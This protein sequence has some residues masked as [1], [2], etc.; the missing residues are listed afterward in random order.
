MTSWLHLGLFLS[1]LS[2]PQALCSTRQDRDLQNLFSPVKD[3][4]EASQ[5]ANSWGYYEVILPAG[6]TQVA[7]RPDNIA[8]EGLYEHL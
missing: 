5:E 2:T 7:P 6:R 1:C 8:I 3:S 4:S